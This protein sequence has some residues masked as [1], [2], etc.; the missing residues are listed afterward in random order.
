M[1]FSLFDFFLQ[2]KKENHHNHGT[3]CMCAHII[4]LS[5]SLFLL[6]LS[7]N[8]VKI[9]KVYI[10]MEPAWHDI[11]SRVRW[12]FVLFF[13]FFFKQSKITGEEWERAFS[14]GI[15]VSYFRVNLYD[16][17]EMM[18]MMMIDM[19][20]S[21][22]MEQ[23]SSLLFIAHPYKKI[24]H[25]YLCPWCVPLLCLFFPVSINRFPCHSE[26]DCNPFLLGLYELVSFR[27]LKKAN[28]EEKRVLLK[29]WLFLGYIIFLDVLWT[30]TATRSIY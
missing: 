29:F 8:H 13:R 7:V 1:I 25:I 19:I 17:D 28:R 27:Q 23:G 30:L 3:L 9:D 22:W 2:M 21:S 11:T 5:F 14:K 18:M 16:D 15:S 10:K 12:T 4:L 24:Y 26:N 20:W 6:Y